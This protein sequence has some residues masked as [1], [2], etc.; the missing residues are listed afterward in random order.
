MLLA[1]STYPTSAQPPAE[2]ADSGPRE[3]TT[4]T[5]KVTVVGK[6]A[7]ET[8]PVGANQQPEWTTRR[9]FSNADVYVQPPLQVEL[10]TGWVVR[11][12][13][14]E[15]HTRHQFLQEIEI[16]LPYRLQADLEL[17]EEIEDG[18]GKFSNVGV[19]LRWALADWGVIFMNPTVY[20]E[21][22]FHPDEADEFEVKLLFGES[23]TQ[24]LFTAVNFFYEQQVGGE[25]EQEF[26]VSN[27][28][29]Y[30]LI[31]RVLGA[32]AE[33]RF[34]LE[35]EK[36]KSPGKQ[37]EEEFEPL[38]VI[39][40]SLSWRITENLSLVAAPLF[41]VTEESPDV[42]SFVFLRYYFGGEDDDAGDEQTPSMEAR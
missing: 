18:N 22:E 10:S 16:G 1:C 33:M 36:E 12:P 35:K 32:G 15:G 39:G 25:D 28:W 7:S 8:E 3:A 26:A 21:W 40:P 38:F 20:G 42:E 37:T 27:A 29:S 23:V 14:E 2:R 13:D 41:G 34:T 11:E 30:S 4:A 9:R 19:E 31:D 6:P 24:R 5:E 17:A